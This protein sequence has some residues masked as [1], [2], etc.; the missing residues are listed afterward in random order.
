MLRQR[1]AFTLSLLAWGVIALSPI[2]QAEA[3]CKVKTVELINLKGCDCLN[4]QCDAWGWPTAYD[5]IAVNASPGQQGND[6][7]NFACLPVGIKHPCIQDWNW[8]NLAL[9]ML[10][11]VAC[12]IACAGAPTGLTIAACLGCFAALGITTG[13]GQNCFLTTCTLDITNPF[14]KD[15]WR[16]DAFGPECTG[17]FPM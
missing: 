6:F 1:I 7:I 10:G 16:A 2:T 8:A 4:N 9:L 13:Q 17:A 12:T 5:E 15:V 11:T 14:P 3:A